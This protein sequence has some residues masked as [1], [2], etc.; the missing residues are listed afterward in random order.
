[1]STVMACSPISPSRDR[2]YYEVPADELADPASLSITTQTEPQ[3]VY[4][5][6]VIFS[7]PEESTPLVGALVTL[8]DTEITP[9]ISFY[10]DDP[11]LLT[12]KEVGT[13]S[14]E[15]ET[16]PEFVTGIFELSSAALT[17]EQMAELSIV[18]T[19]L[20]LGETQGLWSV[21]IAEDSDPIVAQAFKD[22]LVSMTLVLGQI[23]EAPPVEEEVSAEASDEE[24]QPQGDS[25]PLEPNEAIDEASPIEKPSFIIVLKK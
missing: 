2:S 3:T 9:S 5:T 25:E 11:V 18:V 16:V 4:D 23:K 1:M 6:Q 8:S 13:T 20:S 22:S 14:I 15:L 21:S 7:E 10:S 19:K 17:E 12:L 24:K